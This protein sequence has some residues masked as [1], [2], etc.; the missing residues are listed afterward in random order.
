MLKMSSF[1]AGLA[2]NWRER[3]EMLRNDRKKNVSRW[4]ALLESSRIRGSHFLSGQLLALPRFPLR[5]RDKKKRES[6]LRESAG[7]GLG[8]MP[9]YPTSINAIPGLK[10]RIDAGAFPVAESC[11]REVVTLPTHGYLTEDDVSKLR[12]LISRILG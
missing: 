3:L 1:Q 6:L 4:I 9:V 11:A 12:G 10:G 2:S 8:I 7:R 5:I